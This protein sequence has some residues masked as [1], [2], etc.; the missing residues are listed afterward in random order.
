MQVLC[1]ST[2]FQNC[3]SYSMCILKHLTQL[4]CLQALRIPLNINVS[5]NT[6]RIRNKHWSTSQKLNLYQIPLC[7]QLSLPSSMTPKMQNDINSTGTI[8]STTTSHQSPKLQSA[9]PLLRNRLFQCIVT[10]LPSPTETNS[11]DFHKIERRTYVYVYTSL[12]TYSLPTYP[13]Q[14]QLYMR[15]VP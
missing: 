11:R 7:S 6:Q 12:H 5:S 3:S 15:V 14:V 2:N 10:A 13:Y 9:L 4:L 1:T 8:G